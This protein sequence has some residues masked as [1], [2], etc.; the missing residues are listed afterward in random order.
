MGGYSYYK[1]SFVFS[2]G[3]ICWLSKAKILMGNKEI[4]NKGFVGSIISPHALM[5]WL[6]GAEP[7]SAQSALA[8]WNLVQLQRSSIS[9][10]ARIKALKALAIGYKKVLTLPAVDDTAGATQLRVQ[11]SPVDSIACVRCQNTAINDAASPPRGLQTASSVTSVGDCDD[12]I[13]PRPP[14]ILHGLYVETR[15]WCH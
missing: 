12:C 6:Q 8:L 7:R 13:Q 5:L 10:Y 9:V 2:Q 11:S 1:K 15:Q 4:E 14:C 3:C